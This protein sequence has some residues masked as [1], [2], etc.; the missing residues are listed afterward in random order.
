MRKILTASM[1]VGSML[2]LAALLCSVLNAEVES[3][4]DWCEPINPDTLSEE[5]QTKIAF[6]LLTSEGEFWNTDIWL[7]LMPQYGSQEVDGGWGTVVVL[8]NIAKK[9]VFPGGYVAVWF[10]PKKPWLFEQYE[11]V[12]FKSGFFSMPSLK[13]ADRCGIKVLLPWEPVHIGLEIYPIGE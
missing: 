6:S 8:R 11:E 12:I 9:K 5:L 13:L 2:I 3:K 10:Y 1:I 4:A 7:K